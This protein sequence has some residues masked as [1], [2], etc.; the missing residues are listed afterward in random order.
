MPYEVEVDW[1]PAYEL[2]QSLHTYLVH[3]RH[4][5]ALET[6]SA[7]VASVRERG[8]KELAVA[9]EATGGVAGGLGLLIWQCPDKSDVGKVL[10]WILSLSPGEVYERIMS[11]VPE[12]NPDALPA[13]IHAMSETARLVAMRDR[14]VDLLRVWDKVYFRGLDPRIVSGLAQDA[15]MRRAAIRSSAAED[16]I[17]DATCGVR[18]DPTASRARVVLVPQYHFRPVNTYGI[19]RDLVFFHYPVD[20]VPPEPGAPGPALL[21]LTRALSD[22]SRLKILRY[23]SSG[24]RSFTDIVK[25]SGLAK[26]TVHHHVLA[27]RAS[28]LARVHVPF[29]GGPDRYSLRPG[30]IERMGVS[31]VSYVKGE[32]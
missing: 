17:E 31:L 23:L 20:A 15:E 19:L 12:G 13:G 1:S 32:Q 28:G 30:A 29:G 18:L 22:E 8:G 14:M 16:A 6:D 9:V 21:R 7:W 24:E 4:A 5:K 10:D 3:R 25:F 2:V 26:S 11:Y 27:L